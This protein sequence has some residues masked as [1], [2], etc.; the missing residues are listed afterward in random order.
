MDTHQIILILFGIVQLGF[1]W[2][3]NR[4]FAEFEKQRMSIN[5]LFEKGAETRELVLMHRIE[6]L[7]DHLEQ[8]RKGTGNEKA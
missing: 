3:L 5:K 1:S 8:C 7:K 2:I 4:I 6:M